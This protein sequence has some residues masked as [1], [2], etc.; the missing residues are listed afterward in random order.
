MILKFFSY[1]LRVYKSNQSGKIN[2]MDGLVDL[3][4]E[5]LGTDY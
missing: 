1:L 3:I 5:E 2:V 4:G